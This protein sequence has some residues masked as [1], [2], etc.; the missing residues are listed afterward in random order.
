MRLRALI[1]LP[2]CTPAYWY[3]VPCDCPGAP[4]D[5]AERFPQS[6]LKAI[7][8]TGMWGATRSRQ[9]LRPRMNGMTKTEANRQLRLVGWR[10]GARQ[11]FYQRPSIEW[12][13][14]ILNGTGTYALLAQTR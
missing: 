8:I 3:K 14:E 10:N 5:L 9:C 2:A 11:C 12:L 13:R 4:G 7:A 1:V 6:V